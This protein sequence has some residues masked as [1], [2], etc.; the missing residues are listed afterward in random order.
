MDRPASARFGPNEFPRGHG[1]R[2]AVVFN[3]AHAHMGA[4]SKGSGWNGVCRPRTRG[5]DFFALRRVCLACSSA[6]CG[7]SESRLT[8]CK[9][10]LQGLSL[11]AVLIA[12]IILATPSI[13]TTRLRL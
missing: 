1:V 10:A 5:N 4:N 12:F 7:L 8:G 9:E 2:M 11:A 6:L 3:R 13:F